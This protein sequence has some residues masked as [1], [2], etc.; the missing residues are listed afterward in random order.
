MN[1]DLMDK[2][3][4]T[5]RV[6]TDHLHLPYDEMKYSKVKIDESFVKNQ[7]R[8]TVYHDI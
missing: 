6:S 2:I 3:H 7:Y 5:R 1:E 8:R 4:R